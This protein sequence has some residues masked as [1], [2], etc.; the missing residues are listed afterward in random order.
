MSQNTSL[1]GN[2]SFCVMNLILEEQC[3]YACV[4]EISQDR[5]SCCFHVCLVPPH[6]A[7]RQGKG[8]SFMRA[9][10]KPS[11]RSGLCGQW[12]RDQGEK[13]A[14]SFVA[15]ELDTREAIGSHIFG[16]FNTSQDCCSSATILAGS[17]FVP[18]PPKRCGMG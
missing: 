7:H 9:V 13:N 3:A 17:I 12:M 10:I 18:E 4:D 14:I 8:T 11:Q 1:P 2:N 15:S 16:H 6:E 5:F